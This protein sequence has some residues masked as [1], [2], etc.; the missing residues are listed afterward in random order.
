V[1]KLLGNSRGD[2]NIKKKLLRK[3]C[4]ESELKWTDTESHK[5]VGFVLG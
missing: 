5:I 2:K 3:I 4:C 1:K